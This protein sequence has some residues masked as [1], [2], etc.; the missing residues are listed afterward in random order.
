MVRLAWRSRCGS[1]FQ[2][3]NFLTVVRYFHEPKQ[4]E[5]AEDKE[6]GQKTVA[7]DGTQEAPKRTGSFLSRQTTGVMGAMAEG[8]FTLGVSE[9]RSN[10]FL[11]RHTSEGLGTSLPPMLSPER[12]SSLLRHSTDPVVDVADLERAHSK[13]QDAAKKPS[14]DAAKD[15]S[16]KLDAQADEA[17]QVDKLGAF[18]MGWPAWLLFFSS[19][20]FSMGQPGP[21]TIGVLYITEKYTMEI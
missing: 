13:Q 4:S 8:I 6:D 12:K 7:A 10:K 3:L 17:Q 2:F 1:S 14:E 11:R 9:G 15:P 21:M 5:A 19:F 20:L 18:T 16:Q